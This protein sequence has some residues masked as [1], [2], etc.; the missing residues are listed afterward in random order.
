[1]SLES[2]VFTQKS[3]KFETLIPFGFEFNG[4]KYVYTEEMMNGEFRAEISIYKNGTLTG[5]VFDVAAEEEY[6]P[7]HIETRVGAFVGEVRKAYSD[8]LRRICDAC[9]EDSPF[10]SLQSNRIARLI[11]DSYGEA[12]DHPF[13]TLKEAAV[14][15]YP[16]NRKWYA[17]I[18]PVKRSHV[19]KEQADDESNDPLV[20]VMNVKTGEQITPDALKINGIFPAY[21]MNHKSWVSIILDDTV[22]DEK[23]ME[24]INVSRE[25]AIN[26]GKARKKTKA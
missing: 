7:L 18:M 3:P 14:F 26:S 13:E 23:I 4:E 22:S 25:F 6:L 17:L 24:L 9:Y 19:T 5:K 21:H 20:D 8:V 1:M 12:H 11:F 16:Q 2:D 10:S 15:R